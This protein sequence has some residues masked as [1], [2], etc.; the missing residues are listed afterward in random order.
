MRTANNKFS[1]GV[2]V[3]F[4]FIFKQV[5]VFFVFSFYSWYQD[6]FYIVS[7][8]LLHFFFCIKIIMLGGNN[9]GINSGWFIVVIIFQS[10]LAFCIRAQIFYLLIFSSDCC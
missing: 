3:I 2:N 8:F 10:N 7:N 1:R 9:N 6:L 4:Y 5:S